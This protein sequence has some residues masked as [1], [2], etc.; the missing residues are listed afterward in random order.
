M[1]SSTLIDCSERD[2][3]TVDQKRRMWWENGVT[4]LC[5]LASWCVTDVHCSETLWFLVTFLSQV[6]LNLPRSSPSTINGC[7]P[8]TAF[9]S[10]TRTL[11]HVLV[12]SHFKPELPG[13]GPNQRDDGDG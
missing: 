6:F 1:T 4:N 13:P 9:R 5:L 10:H 8:P 11:S 12:Q 7:S 3:A 2:V